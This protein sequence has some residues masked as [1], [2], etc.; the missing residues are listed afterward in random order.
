MQKHFQHVQKIRGSMLFKQGQKTDY[1]YILKSGEVRCKLMQFE[2]KPDF[3]DTDT[4]KIFASPLQAN[5]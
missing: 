2:Q 4:K 3:K 5:S 1:I